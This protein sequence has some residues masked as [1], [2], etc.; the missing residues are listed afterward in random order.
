MYFSFYLILRGVK[1]LCS[2]VTWVLNRKYLLGQLE[3]IKYYKEAYYVLWIT[4]NE[5][6]LLPV[7]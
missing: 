1:I 7:L 5:P 6:H 3:F 2:L 4:E